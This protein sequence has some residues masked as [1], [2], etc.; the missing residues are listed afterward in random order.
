[1]KQKACSST[2]V[3]STRLI[4]NSMQERVRVALPK[5]GMRFRVHIVSEA[6][7]PSSAYFASSSR[8][9]LRWGSEVDISLSPGLGKRRGTSPRPTFVFSSKLSVSRRTDHLAGGL[10]DDF[11]VVHHEAATDDGRGGLAF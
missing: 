5:M 2:S 11:A 9:R 3:A 10:A 1:M 8:I 4:S 7:W 6:I